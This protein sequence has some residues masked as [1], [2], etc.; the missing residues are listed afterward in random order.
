MQVLLDMPNATTNLNSLRLFYDTIATHT[1]ALAS[2]GKS[3]ESYG[4]IL[5][6]IILKKLPTEVQL[7][8][9]VRAHI[10]PNPARQSQISQH[11]LISEEGGRDISANKNYNF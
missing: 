8:C 2:L 11:E 6:S 5:V 7:V 10:L 1:R 3:K 4:D 9:F